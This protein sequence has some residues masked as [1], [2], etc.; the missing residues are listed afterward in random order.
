MNLVKFLRTL[1]LKNT[2][3]RR[4]LLIPRSRSRIEIIYNN[5]LHNFQKVEKK[6]EFFFKF[7]KWKIYHTLYIYLDIFNFVEVENAWSMFMFLWS[8]A[9]LK[10]QKQSP[11]DVKKKLKNGVL[12]HF[13]KFI[14][15]HLRQ[16]LFFNKV[17]GWDLQIYTSVLLWLRWIF[18]RTTFFIEHLR[19]LLLKHIFISMVS[20][21]RFVMDHIF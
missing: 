5:F 15:K 6:M 7:L 8:K 14:G 11:G 10:H 13:V 18:F 2:S 3:W 19:W 1:F 4:L 16:S 17:I 21:S 12:K 20:Y 9:R